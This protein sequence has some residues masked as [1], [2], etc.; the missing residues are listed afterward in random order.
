MKR[1]DTEA[2]HA[3]EEEIPFGAISFPVYLSST[4]SF[5]SSEEAGAF[6]SG[7]GEG[8]AYTRVSNPTV[9]AFERKMA[10][11]EGAEA[12][13]AF[14]SG[15][16]AL[17]SLVLMLLPPGGTLVCCRSVYS[18]THSFIDRVLTP[19]GYRVV[20]FNADEPDIESSIRDLAGDGAD[21]LLFETPTNPELRI[22]DMSRIAGIARSLGLPSII[23]STFAT[24]ALQQPLGHGIDYVVHSATKYI[25]GHGDI[26]GGVALGSAA[27]MKT[28]RHRF[29]TNLGGCMSP[30]NAWLFLRGLKTLPVRMERHSALA[31]SLAKAVS[32]HPSVKTVLYPGLPSHPGHSIAAAQMR[33]FGGMLSLILHDRESG[34]RFLD[35]LKLA[36]IAVSLGDPATLVLH[37][38]SMTHV[39]MKDDQMREKGVDPALVRIS[40]GLED[41]ESI[42]ED[43]LNALELL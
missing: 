5:D 32:G 42:N 24:P 33:A 12:A 23:D 9:E 41:S 8:Y 7:R 21:A 19:M 14:S 28:L 10:T 20:Y 26:I 3:G 43:I 36:K 25:G 13:V 18:G 35:H 11:L 31:M 30:M 39:G 2:V 27:S 22:L 15:M 38:G 37:P 34:R 1:F 40:V 17:S 6:F 4:F 29:L 16:S